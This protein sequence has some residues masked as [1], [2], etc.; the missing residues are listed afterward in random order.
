MLG[1]LSSPDRIDKEPPACYDFRVCMYYNQKNPD[2]SLCKEYQKECLNYTRFEYCND[3]NNTPGMK[4]QECWDK[5][6]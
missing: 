3:D 2:K 5:L 1:C 6:K 4:F